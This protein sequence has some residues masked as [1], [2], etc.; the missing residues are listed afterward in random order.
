MR[1]LR[2]GGRLRSI[3]SVVCLILVMSLSDQSYGQSQSTVLCDE[4]GLASAV[5]ELPAEARDWLLVTCTPK[6]QVLMPKV[7][8]GYLWF[9]TGTRT[10]FTLPVK[11]DNKPI[12]EIDG[13][14]P[15][16]IARF[17]RFVGLERTGAARD[18]VLGMLDKV[19]AADQKPEVDG[20]YQLDAYSVLYGVVF[21]LF[22]FTHDG[23]PVTLVACQR[24]CQLSVGVDVARVDEIISN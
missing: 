6:G 17:Q 9:L 24:R 5:A 14:H 3:V 12:P 21:N 18:M 19:Y 7:E 16:E 11:T 15:S 22:F 1:T 8:N 13:L 20:V 23:R 10:P 2:V 4:L